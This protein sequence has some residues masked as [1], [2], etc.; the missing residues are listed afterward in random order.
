MTNRFGL[1]DFV[2]LLA[3]VLV[4]VGVFLAMVQEDRRWD[5]VQDLLGKVSSLEK[6]VA[7]VERTLESGGVAVRTPGSAAAAVPAQRDESWARPGVRVDWQEPWD[8]TSDPHQ[9]D[10]FQPGGEFVETFEAQMP[11]VMP[12]LAQDVYARRITD[13]VFDRLGDYDPAKLTIRGVLAEAWQYD[14]EGMWLRVKLWDHARFHDGEPVRAED[15][16]YT[17]MDFILNPELETE[18]VRSI[19]NNVDAVTVVSERVVEFRF[20]EPLYSNL[21][22]ALNYEVLPKHYYEQFT[23]SQ[24]NQATGLLVGSGPFRLATMDPNDQWTPGTDFVVVRNESYWG[25]AKPA[26]DRLRFRTITDDLAS[27]TAF[28]NGESDMMRPSS[29][30]FTDTLKQDP[31]FE[32]SSHA[33]N[34]VNMRSG[35]SFIAWQCGPRNGQ[36]LTPFHDKRVRLAMTMLLDR[37]R[38]IDDISRGIG[39]IATGPNNSVSPASAPDVTPWP[40]DL[41]RA[42]AL[43]AEAGWIDRDNDGIIENEQGEPFEWEFTYSTGSESVVQMVNYVQ[44]QCALAGIRMKHNAIDWSIFVDVL[45]ARNFDA[46]TL[47]WSASTPES[48]PRQIWHSASIQ[49]QGD[50]FIQWSNAEGD[51]LIDQGRATLD[52]QAR[53]EV[54]Q[55]LHRVIH[56]DQ[57]YTFLR[58]IPWLRFVDKQFKNVVPYPKGIEQIEYYF[59]PGPGF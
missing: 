13:L 40:Y 50:N 11:K 41:A 44:S 51:R 31:D 58:E 45:N 49:N 42:K 4:G 8:F 5:Q 27:L 1:K 29:S 10:D 18:R 34:W 59:V 30:Q 26:L 32:R 35:Y 57:P 55:A 37:Q 2:L 23:P 20:K 24:I 12:F 54:W 16:A 43:L 28:R 48:D 21:S 9:F 36:R 56:E 19:V 14:P 38:L 7:R 6:Q 52:E 33:L 39:F 47:A 46:I 17:W 3:V 15:V 53:M 25:R 22:V